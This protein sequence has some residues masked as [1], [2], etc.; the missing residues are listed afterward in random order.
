[1]NVGIGPRELLGARLFSPTHSP[2]KNNSGTNELRMRSAIWSGGP[3]VADEPFRSQNLPDYG[4]DVVVL[5]E[6]GDQLQLMFAEIVA[7]P[8][9]DEMQSLLAD[10]EQTSKGD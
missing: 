3:D 5:K 7:E 10:L 6:I 1:M 2:K 9:P 4:V 8:L